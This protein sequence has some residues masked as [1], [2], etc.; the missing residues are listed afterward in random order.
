MCLYKRCEFCTKVKLGLLMAW[1]TEHGKKDSGHVCY[2]CEDTVCTM[3][4]L[5]DSNVRWLDS[6]DGCE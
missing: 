3:I 4:A 2:G 6:L 1:Q 5:G